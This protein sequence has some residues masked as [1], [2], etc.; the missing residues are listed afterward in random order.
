MLSSGRHY[1]THLRCCS[2][3]H[4]HNAG[5]NYTGM[6][7]GMQLHN[8][9][10]VEHMGLTG[11][12]GNDPPTITHHTQ[13]GI[14][15]YC[16]A[17]T[18]SCSHTPWK[19]HSTSTSTPPPFSSTAPHHPLLPHWPVGTG[20]E[21]RQAVDMLLQHMHASPI[22][23]TTC[24]ASMPVCHGPTMM[25]QASCSA[26]P[27]TY[28]DAECDAVGMA[29]ENITAQQHDRMTACHS[30]LIGGAVLVVTRAAATDGGSGRGSALSGVG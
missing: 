17:P 23:F 2:I 22:H 4:M 8:T 3:T 18:P 30:H 13:S 10:Y 14:R 19:S 26:T 24:H 11:P 25:H 7:T 29:H 20:G 12:N 15:P 6:H 27:T 5:K 16:A 9:N 1:P 21:P 28:D